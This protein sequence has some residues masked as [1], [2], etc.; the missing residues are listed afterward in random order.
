MTRKQQRLFRYAVDLFI[1]LLGQVT[2]RR[3]NYKCND[4]DVASFEKFLEEFGDGIG[5]NFVREFT[6]YGI[7]SW[8]NDGNPRDYSRS[9]RISWIFGSNAIK[10]WYALPGHARTHYVRGYLK[11]NHKINVIKRETTLPQLLT[12][13]RLAEENHKARFYNTKRGLAWCVANTTLYFHKSTYCA[14][15]EFKDVCKETLKTEFPKVY[16][17]RGYGEE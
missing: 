4:A 17:Q 8:F 7:Q 14:G 1:Q 10:R 16:K 9:V 15:C 3:V 11:K 2:H 12:S 13:L 6:E 5:E